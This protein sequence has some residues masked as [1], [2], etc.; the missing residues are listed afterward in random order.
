MAGRRPIDDGLPIPWRRKGKG[1]NDGRWLM[2]LGQAFDPRSNALN[3]I[4][5]ALA[6][7]VILLHSFQNTGRMPPAA[8]RQ[9]L[10]SVGVDGF[11]AI[12]GFL[13]TSSWLSHPR[14][15][16][17]LVAR[18][19]RI[20]PGFYV[21][22]VVTA[23][24]FAP[25]SVAI[26]GRS[27][28]KLLWSTAPFEFIWKNSA[29]AYLHP[30]VG[31]TP[32]GIPRAGD[33][34]GSLW[35][36][37]YEVMCYLAVAGIGIAG[38]ANRK[39]VS[40]AIVALA[41]FLATLLPPLT[42]SVPWTIPQLLVRSAIT[43][44]AGALIYQWRDLI[45]ARWSLVMVSAVIVVLAA[46]LLPDYRVVAAIPLAYAVIVTGALIHKKRL[47]LRTDLSYG[48]YIYAFPI[49]QLL[50]ICGLGNLNPLV[51][52]VI[53]TVA[54]LPLAAMSWFLVEKRAMSIKSRLLRKWS[55]Q[56]Q[57]GVRRGENVVLAD[58]MAGQ[59]ASEAPRAG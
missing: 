27:V 10:M 15:R 59:P 24:V 55:Q 33:W 45:P 4:R 53:S 12:S 58:D 42:L 23:F 56:A 25:L 14:V 47:R 34:N 57:P 31:G 50:I 43:F 32:H 18:A 35:S 11:F 46:G 20:F 21:C 19:L 5:L 39:W 6:T 29:V 41:V 9:L 28:A 36:L 30:N 54:T 1:P 3:V 40:P 16:D 22:L 13:I 37:V 51:F 17:Y 48:T 2:K 7:E 49:Q 52:F 38:L 44:A 26:Q 8:I